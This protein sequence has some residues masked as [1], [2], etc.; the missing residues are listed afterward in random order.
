MGQQRTRRVTRCIFC[1]NKA[2]SREHAWPDWVLRRFSSYTAGPIHSTI[3]GKIQNVDLTQRSLKVRCVCQP[4]NTGW[5]KRLE[6][7]VIPLVSPLMHDLGKP[8]DILQQSTIA[9]WAVKT[10]MVFEYATDQ[11]PTI[12][13]TD[14]DREQLKRKELPPPN[15]SVWLARCDGSSAFH[16]DARDMLTG[17]PNL[18]EI[19]GHVTT[20]SYKHLAIQVLSFRPAMHET[21][22]IEIQRNSPLPWDR[23]ALRIWPTSRHTFWPPPL[24]LDIK[25]GMSLSDFCGVWIHNSSQDKE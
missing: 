25:P 11:K 4:C 20:L 3:Q 16:T 18:P 13:Y 2:D 7:T 8:L 5:M 23:A 10:V 24:S 21:R 9:L 6:D 17:R 15:T 14:T 12:F 22:T 19:R 1:P